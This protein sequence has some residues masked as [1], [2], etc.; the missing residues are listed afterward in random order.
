MLRTIVLFVD[1]LVLWLLLSGIFTPL[2]LTLGFISCLATTAIIIRMR[3][4]NSESLPAQVS[5]TALPGYLVWLLKEIAKANWAVTKIILS[6]RCVLQQ[7][8]FNVPNSQTTDVGKV[9]FANSITLTPG[10]IT[11]ETEHGYFVI[12][13]L[14]EEAADLDALADMDRRVSIVENKVAFS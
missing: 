9:I 11:V 7:K 3:I 13:A 5:I 4:L 10:T 8:L 6:P 2:L 12:H 1:L 14:T